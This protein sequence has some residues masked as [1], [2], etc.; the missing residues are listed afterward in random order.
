[1]AKEPQE[2]RQYIF[3]EAQTRFFF[4]ATGVL[5]VSTIVGLLLLATVQPQGNFELPDRRQYIETVTSAAEDLSGGAEN[6]DGSVT[7]SIERAIELVAERGV[8]DPFTVK[9][10]E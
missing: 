8:V 9:T 2:T 1:M 3:S 6:T 10:S 7:I 4:A 5:M